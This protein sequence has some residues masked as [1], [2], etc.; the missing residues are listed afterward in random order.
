MFRFQP[1]S[2]LPFTLLYKWVTCYQAMSRFVRW[3]SYIHPIQLL[4]V[5]I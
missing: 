1:Y 4:A 3:F 5:N 2:M